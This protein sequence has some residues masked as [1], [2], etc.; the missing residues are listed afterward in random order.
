MWKIEMRCFL[1]LLAASVAIA[2]E[3]IPA[4]VVAG[5]KVEAN[6]KVTVG[7]KLVGF[8]D[9]KNYMVEV[10]DIKKGGKEVR[11]HWIGFGKEEDVDVDPATL[12]YVA[13]TTQTRKSRTSVLPKEY[14]SYDKNGD[15]QIGLYEWE[16]A[17]YAEF[18]KLDKNHD[19][20][21]TPQELA[22]KVVVANAATPA[23][24]ATDAAAAPKN[25]PMPDPGN[26]DSYT[27]MIGKSFTFTVK[28]SAEGNVVGT[29]VFTTSSDLAAA[30]VHAGV[31]KVGATGTV[32][33]SIIASPES[34][35]GSTSNGVTSSDGPA[36]TAA[37]T[38]K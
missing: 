13:D 5:K 33:A 6:A 21:L 1:I 27:G 11:I 31:L 4:N 2:K 25:D 14:Q 7:T 28:G 19:G 22:S 24:A 20:F 3:E 17:K 26:L 18:K 36:Y 34:Y 37:Y 23:S 32:T 16:R 15:G 35:K 12:Y 29:G 9:G 10:T 30:A 8:F 38:V